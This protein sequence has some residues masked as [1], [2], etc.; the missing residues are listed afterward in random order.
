MHY[1]HS[2]S[3]LIHGFIIMDR[4]LI[5]NLVDFWWIFGETYGIQAM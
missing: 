3:N 1:F 4:I 5:V 2:F